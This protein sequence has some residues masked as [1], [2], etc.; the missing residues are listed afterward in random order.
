MYALQTR[1]GRLCTLMTTT[2]EQYLR[3]KLS[4]AYLKEVPEECSHIDNKLEKLA[5]W[6]SV[7]M[8]CGESCGVLELSFKFMKKN[9]LIK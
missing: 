3:S 1:A 9:A 6:D 4:V 8:T 5:V 7:E 2:R